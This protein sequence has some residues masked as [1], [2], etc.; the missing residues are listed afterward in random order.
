MALYVYYCETCNVYIE[1]ESS[2]K[3]KKD[4]NLMKCSACGNTPKRKYNVKVPILYK[5]PGFYVTDNPKESK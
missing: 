4:D 1:H 3:D 2:P 5:A